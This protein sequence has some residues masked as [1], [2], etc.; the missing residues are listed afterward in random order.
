MPS[1]DFVLATAFTRSQF[2]GNP[3]ATIFLN[4]DPK[5]SSLQRQQDVDWMQNVAATLNQ[6]IASFVFPLSN[7]PAE[8]EDGTATVGI[9]WFTTGIE[10]PLC[11]HGL[12]VAA[13]L[14][15]SGT[16]TRP[17]L[18]PSPANINTI[19]FVSGHTGN[20]VTARRIILVDEQTGFKSERVEIELPMATVEP[21][22]GQEFERIA[23]VVSNAVGRKLAPEMTGPVNEGH[24][25]VRFVG[26][27]AEGPEQK[28][29]FEFYVLVEV[30]CAA[31]E[32]L[33]GLK[34]D[35]NVL[36]RFLPSLETMQSFLLYHN[37]SKLTHSTSTSLPPAHPPPRSHTT[38]ACSPR[39]PRCTR[40]TSVGA[41]IA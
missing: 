10:V 18:I 14:L 20:T 36:V 31:G 23:G 6:P 41:R 32:S 12:L 37:R 26:K 9:R 22:S 35:T 25:K 8:V 34:V 24:I 2:G 28:G 29:G 7:P 38:R 21:V 27:G 4:A 19:H 40:T 1:L 16:V 13:H 15:F 33:G 5:G 11:G 3:A 39:A 17:D 30:E